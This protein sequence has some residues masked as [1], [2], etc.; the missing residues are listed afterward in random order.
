MQNAARRT[1]ILNAF[2][3]RLFLR[4]VSKILKTPKSSPMADD[5]ITQGGI[6][7]SNSGIGG[8]GS[9]ESIEMLKFVFN[10]VT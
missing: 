8:L 1:K 10:D 7:S 2:V 6:E 9:V 5:A 4:V 3:L